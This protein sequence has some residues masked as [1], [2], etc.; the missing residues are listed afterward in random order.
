LGERFN[1]I[2]VS[3]PARKGRPNHPTPTAVSNHKNALN[4]YLKSL[5]NRGLSPNYIETSEMFL[6]FQLHR[7]NIFPNADAGIRSAMVKLYGLNKQVSVGRLDNISEIWSPYKSIASRFLWKGLDGGYF[8]GSKH[9][10]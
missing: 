1:G 7:Q 4:S 2:E 5:H 9:P 6:I 3:P 10:K 8:K